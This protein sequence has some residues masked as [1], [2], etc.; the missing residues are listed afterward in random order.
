MRKDAWDITGKDQKVVQFDDC[1]L[2]SRDTNN[3][4]RKLQEAIGTCCQG[5]QYG[6]F[7]GKQPGQRTA[8]SGWQYQS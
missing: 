2:L 6:H 3:R 4:I 5:N 1:L 8:S 7:A